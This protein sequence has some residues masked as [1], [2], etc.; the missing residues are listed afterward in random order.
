MHCFF[1]ADLH[2]SE[3]R[4]NKL[5]AA[6]EK[7]VPDAVLWGGDLLPHGYM[8]GG[9]GSDFLHDFLLK[10]FRQFKSRMGDKYP[11]MF[12]IMG[13]D[14]VRRAEKTFIDPQN[15][16][17]WEYVHFKKAR[18]GECTI[19]GYTYVPPTPFRLK[20]WERYDIDF[21][22]RNGCMA[23]DKGI[24]TVPFDADEYR[25]R[26]IAADL[27]ELTGQ[28]DLG[29]A[30]LMIHTPPHK[31]NLDRLGWAGIPEE[32]RHVGSVA[33]RRLIE[34]R[35]PLVV[36]SGHIHESPSVTGSWQDRI[37]DTV[38]ISAAHSG[39]ELAIVKFDPMHPASAVRDLL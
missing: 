5:L 14:D 15:D 23:P 1:V 21:T 8:S 37:G 16:G 4:Y 9:G 10:E 12:L 2:G 38:C 26:T 25:S 7:E 29:R 19:Y 36:L 33:L 6:I 3:S 20:D 30:I 13:N 31:T 39:P 28:D 17:L 22:M 32:D 24:H 18:L 34:E 27:N 11:R 35:H